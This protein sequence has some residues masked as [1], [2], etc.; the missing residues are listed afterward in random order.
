MLSEMVTDNVLCAI[1][2]ALA[3]RVEVKGLR[4]KS[5]T[6]PV[7]LSYNANQDENIHLDR[8]GKQCP[9]CPTGRMLRIEASLNA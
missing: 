1:T 7:A 6:A 4:L 5:H 9:S 3:P 2:P 8:R